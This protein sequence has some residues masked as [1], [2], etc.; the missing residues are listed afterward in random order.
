[1]PP[2]VDDS[3]R[4]QATIAHWRTRC[5]KGVSLC[6]V[7][8]GRWVAPRSF[9]FGEKFGHGGL[10]GLGP[11]RIPPFAGVQQVRHDLLGE[12][13]VIDQELIVDIQEEHSLA[14]GQFPEQGIGSILELAQGVILC[15][16]AREGCSPP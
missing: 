1:M 6:Y 2:P 8:N 13:S 16:T 9:F 10:N 14:I 4:Q 12:R 11:Q 5:F 7:S 15:G 3:V